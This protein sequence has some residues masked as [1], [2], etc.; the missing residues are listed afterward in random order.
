MPRRSAYRVRGPIARAPAAPP[1]RVL[2]LINNLRVGG[3]ERALVNFVNH[4][5][6]IRPAV[7]LIE[8]TG[9]FLCELNPGLEVFSLDGCEPKRLVVARRQA[10]SPAAPHKRLGPPRS[11][12]LLELPG[13]VRKALRLARLARATEASVVSAFLNRSY[14]IAL[15]AKFLFAPRLRVVLN[16]QEMLSH[17]LERDFGPVERRFMRVFITRAFP[18]AWRI[19][20]ISDGVRDDLVHHFSIPI[21][22]ISVVANPI[23]LKRIRRASEER[24]DD[25]GTRQA[26]ALVVGVGRLVRLKGFD[27]LIRA[28][29]RLPRT[30]PARLVIIGEGA[31]RPAL[32]RLIV[33]LGVANRATLLGVQ[34]NPWKYMARAHVVVLPS[35]TE[36][37]GN[38]IGEAMALSVPVVA[39]RCSEGVGEYL[40]GGRCGLLVPPEDV[41]ALAEA[42]ERVLTDDG[43]RRQLAQW[44]AERA[45]AFDL[46]RVV[47]QYETLITEAPNE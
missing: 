29:A 18:R 33:E 47:P 16:V 32:E 9:H 30:L 46:P 20:A 36:G 34:A 6:R 28:F 19:V 17:T 11:Q 40:D 8:A 31:E 3:A 24:E 13:L 38:V 2:F 26:S 12:I 45:E 35:R 42:L 44:G 10:V 1:Q 4:L 37:L 21:E 23:D 5:K 43:L 27:L 41:S 22:Q 15:V 25:A 7:V 14:T 39:A